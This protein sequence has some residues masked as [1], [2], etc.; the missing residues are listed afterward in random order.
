MIDACERKRREPSS[1]GS[2][3]NDRSLHVAKLCGKAAIH[4]RCGQSVEVATKYHRFNT[5]GMREPLRPQQ[6][7]GLH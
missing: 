1:L 7:F 4:F 3:A 6:F 2:M 5:I